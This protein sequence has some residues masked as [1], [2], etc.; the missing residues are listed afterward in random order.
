MDTDVKT[1]MIEMDSE[2]QLR[3]MA[4]DIFPW[5][6]QSIKRSPQESSIVLCLK[7]WTHMWRGRKCK[8]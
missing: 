2:N 7:K 4:G 1:V 8:I 6:K 5:K 3:I